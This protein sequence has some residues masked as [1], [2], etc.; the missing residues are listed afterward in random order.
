M[1]PASLIA[2]TLLLVSCGAKPPSMGIVSSTL[3]AELS[4][5]PGKPPIHRTSSSIALL[6]EQRQ[7]AGKTWS[8]ILSADGFS[9]WTEKTLGTPGLTSVVPTLS[10]FILIDKSPDQ[11]PVE[12]AG[13]L[14]VPAGVKGTLLGATAKAHPSA[15]DLLRL[16]AHLSRSAPWL[17]LE[18]GNARGYAPAEWVLFRADPAI[19]T[20]A[21]GLLRHPFLTPET[22]VGKMPRAGDEAI[23]IADFGGQQ[24]RLKLEADWKEVEAFYRD[25]SDDSRKLT[26][27]RDGVKRLVQL[28]DKKQTTRLLFAEH[29]PFLHRIDG[30]AGWL[31]EIAFLYGDGAYSL[32]VRLSQSGA[33]TVEPLSHVSGEEGAKQITAGWGVSDG[34]LWIAKADAKQT[35]LQKFGEKPSRTWLAVIAESAE[36]RTFAAEG[37]VI[38]YT[39]GGVIVWLTAVPFDTEADA[40][41][42]VEQHPGTKVVSL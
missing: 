6:L 38:P 10:K 31:I 33:V 27:F 22:A 9:G 19:M 23:A 14:A 26:V 41:Q 20:S 37:I 21:V 5:D 12:S 8:R 40:K 25:P 28:E 32:L 30:G 34:K 36:P 13:E 2:F 4:T 42:W 15:M 1:R 17:Y 16:P 3:Y 39:R 35:T 24:T 7:Q 29:Q 11:E 18:F